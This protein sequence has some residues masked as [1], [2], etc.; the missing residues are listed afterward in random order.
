MTD[1]GGIKRPVQATCP[2][3][4]G[5]G[6]FSTERNA[7]TGES[8]TKRD[9]NLRHFSSVRE[10]TDDLFRIRNSYSQQERLSCLFLEEFDFREFTRTVAN[11]RNFDESE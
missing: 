9:L 4:D 11:T 7:N 10:L 5:K 6:V 2:Q 8:K 1:S 3:I